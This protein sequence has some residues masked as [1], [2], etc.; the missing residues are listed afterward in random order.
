[1]GRRAKRTL[2]GLVVRQAMRRQV[3]AL[4]QETTIDHSI[5][6]LIKYKVNALLVTGADGAPVGVVSKSDIMGAYYAGLP[7]TSPLEHIMVGPPLFCRPHEAL[8]EALDLMRNQGVYRLYVV[9]GNEDRTNGVLAYPDIVGLLYRYCHS[10][11][12]SHRNQERVSSADKI[13]RYVIGE[14]M[15]KQVQAIQARDTTL[16]AMELLSRLHHQP[17]PVGQLVRVRH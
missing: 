4:P 7:I 9:D 8:E 16:E 11:E 6:H 14:V 12:F 1:M 5:N 15:T 10:C 17:H 3:I 2:S 13:K